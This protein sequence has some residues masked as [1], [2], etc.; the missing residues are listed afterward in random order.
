MAYAS[1][2][3]PS[4][5]FN[6]K[7]YTGTGSSNAITGVGFQ[8]DWTW[9]KNRDGTDDHK[10]FDS[11]RGVTKVLKPNTDGAETTDSNTLTAFGTDGF[12]V[13]SDGGVNGNG[14]DFASWNW[15]AAGAGSSNSDGTI[16]S[17][18]SANTT[19][20]FS[21][22]GWTGN[23]TN[24]A[25]VGHG[26]GVAPEMVMFKNRGATNSW[27]VYHRDLQ[28]R[29]T[30]CLLLDGTNSQV[31]GNNYMY[32][33]IPS[34]SLLYLGNSA[35][36]NENGIN[37]IAYC[38]KSIKGFSKVGSYPGNGSNTNGPFIYTGFKPAFVMLKVGYASAGLDFAGNWNIFDNRRDGINPTTK[39]LLPNST[40]AEASASVQA[41]DFLSN[42]FKVNSNNTDQNSSSGVYMYY[43]VAEEPLVANVGQSIPATAE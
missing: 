13:G 6:T 12:T 23:N 21:V 3:K 15:K 1:I 36:T 22:V 28:T 10:A 25:T 43:A 14:D 17:T 33:T 19:A 18:V 2:T 35:A 11:L 38:F 16:A 31:T 39:R 32:G 8:P 5:Q 37:F 9:I 30:T 29:Q 4:L 7:L 26:L 34:S 27:H 41:I 20:G 42:G 24:G 40:N